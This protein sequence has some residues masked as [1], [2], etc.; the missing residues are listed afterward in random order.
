LL[1]DPYL[2]CLINH[3]GEKRKTSTL[4]NIDILTDRKGSVKQSFGRS[5]GRF[6]GFFNVVQSFFGHG[7]NTYTPESP[8]LV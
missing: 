3:Q 1:N 4:F 6:Q 7:Q 2:P 8:I 5:F